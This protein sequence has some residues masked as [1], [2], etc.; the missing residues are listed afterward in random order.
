MAKIIIVIAPPTTNIL[1]KSGWKNESRI[2]TP[3]GESV[4]AAV[5]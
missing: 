2:S 4:A 3:D 1:L 5:K